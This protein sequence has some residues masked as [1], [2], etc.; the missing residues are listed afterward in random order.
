[1]KAGV[2]LYS[3]LILISLLFLAC[4]KLESPHVLQVRDYP[5]WYAL[6]TII[7]HNRYEIIGYGEGHTLKEA[8]AVAKEDIAQSV[9]SRVESS[10]VG[11]YDDNGGENISSL[12]VTSKLNLQNI[13]VLKQEQKRDLF[14]VALSYENLDLPH[15]IKQTLNLST[16]HNE[17]SKGY[18]KNT[19]L[20]KKIYSV[21]GCKLDFQLERANGAW[22][23]RYK[24][25][26]F[27]LSDEEFEELYLDVFSSKFEF[28]PSKK[29][30]FDGDSFYFV[31]KA[32]QKGYITLLDVYENGI[33]T[34]LHPSIRIKHILQIPSK[35][36]SEYFEAGLVDERKDTY[37]LYV[38]VFSKKPLDMSRFEY[39]D[40]ELV[41]SEVAY[42]FDELMQKLRDYEFATVLLRT[43]AK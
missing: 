7:S 1:V 14:F 24:K 21:L 25:D 40:E 16:C 37:D 22:Y 10:F 41:T 15:K 23:L 35:Q 33:V 36:S 4:A 2:F 32:K 19:L 34:L 3:G 6:K 28:K 9:F 30:L 43:K 42:K 17:S 13:K 39:A 29:V 27:L 38:A 26:R 31:F 18:F 5:H 20:F 8:K 11:A 12:K